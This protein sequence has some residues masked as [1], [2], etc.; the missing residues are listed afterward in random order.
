MMKDILYVEINLKSPD[1]LKFNWS[2]LFSPKKVIF[3][4]KKKKSFLAAPHSI[5]SSWARDQIWASAVATP[6]PLTY[7]ARLGFD[8]CCTTVRTS[9]SGFLG[10]K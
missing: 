5:W 10:E 2:R 1:K 3:F 8:S 4:L 6:D 9:E 7:P